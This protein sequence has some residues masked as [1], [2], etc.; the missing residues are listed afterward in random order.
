MQLT[1]WLLITTKL[2]N[3]V[4]EL[5]ELSI[6]FFEMSLEQCFFEVSQSMKNIVIKTPKQHENMIYKQKFECVRT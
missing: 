2:N 3:F 4:I 5:M 6:I 1:N